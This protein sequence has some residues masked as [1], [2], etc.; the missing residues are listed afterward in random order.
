MERREE[1]SK[2]KSIMKSSENIH[3]QFLCVSESSRGR[4]EKK[5]AN[6]ARQAGAEHNKTGN[7]KSK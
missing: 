3:K 6:I 5:I 7:M 2:N 1:E 4:E